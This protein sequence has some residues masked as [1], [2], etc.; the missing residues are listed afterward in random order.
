[1][2]FEPLCAAYGTSCLATLKR[3]LADGHRSLAGLLDEVGAH[4]IP[5][6]SLGSDEEISSAFTNV[7]TPADAAKVETMLTRSMPALGGSRRLGG[8]P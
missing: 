7:N 4:R 5:M 2:K 1:M 3:R 6:E 8:D